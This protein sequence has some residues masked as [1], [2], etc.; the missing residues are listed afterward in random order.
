MDVRETSFEI[1][2]ANVAIF[3]DINELCVPEEL[4]LLLSLFDLGLEEVCEFVYGHWITLTGS[5]PPQKARNRQFVA[6]Q[7]VG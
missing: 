5:K 7:E 2:L 1:L 3:V 4:T 6:L